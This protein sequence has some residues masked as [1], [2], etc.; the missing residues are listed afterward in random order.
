MH[1][2]GIAQVGVPVGVRAAHRL[3]LEVHERGAAERRQRRVALHHVE[4][5]RERHAAA[6][7]WGHGVDDVA[8]IRDLDRGTPLGA[9]PRQ[10]LFRDEPAAPL[11]LPHDQ[12]GDPAA[13]EHLRP[14]VRDSRQGAREIGLHQARAG[15][16]CGAIH[17]ELRARGREQRQALGLEPDLPAAYGVEEEAIARQLDRGRD[18]VL[19]RQATVLVMRRE[20][21]GDA[22]GHAHREMSGKRGWRH[23]PRRIDVHVAGDSLRRRFTVVERAHRSVAQA[24]DHEP[25]TSDVPGDRMDDRQGEP[26]RDSGVHRVATPAQHVHA[27]FARDLVRGDDDGVFRRHGP[28]SL[29]ERPACGNEQ[30]CGGG[31]SARYCPWGGCRGWGSGCRAGYGW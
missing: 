6:R 3:G 15:R 20:Q 29:G 2:V 8:A 28:H 22:P 12:V 1:E 31:G 25:A 23:V 4:D 18:D 21:A 19:P 17:Q 9:V 13:V 11:H 16:R 30:P 10:V 7:G 14:A 5:L 24:D 27:Y 26:D